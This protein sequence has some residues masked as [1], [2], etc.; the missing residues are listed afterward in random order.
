[1]YGPSYPQIGN[2]L[3]TTDVGYGVLADL[4]AFLSLLFSQTRSCVAQ[5]GLTVITELRITL[6]SSILLLSLPKFW[7]HRNEPPGLGDSWT[8]MLP[9]QV[10]LSGGQKEEWE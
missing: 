5:A 6:I 8:Q 4:W 1:M 2:P 7:A 3:G 10:V 9:A